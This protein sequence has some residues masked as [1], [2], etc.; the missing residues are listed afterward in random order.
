M[1]EEDWWTE[2]TVILWGITR[3][4]FSIDPHSIAANSY[5]IFKR[6]RYLVATIALLLWSLSQ[7]TRLGVFP[8]EVTPSLQKSKF[9]VSDS[10]NHL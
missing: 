2:P 3:F 8:P 4:C 1:C 5:C 6:K 10:L 9:S 7:V